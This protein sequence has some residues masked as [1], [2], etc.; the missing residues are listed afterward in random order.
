MA[1][2]KKIE[3]SR[4][5]RY[6]ITVFS[7]R[8]MSGKQ[9]RHFKTWTPPAG[10]SGRALEKELKRAAYEFESQIEYG[11]AP[12]DRR[13][14]AEYAAYCI[15]L[16]ERRG[17]KPSTVA[18][19]KRQVER[20]NEYIGHMRVTDIRPK[21]LN[22]LYK[23]LAQPGAS[24][25]NVF[26]VP[27]ADFRELVGN[28]TYKQ[29]A[30]K[31]G[32]YARLIC[33]LVNGQPISLENAKTIEKNLGRKDLFS[34]VNNDRPMSPGTIR[35]YHELISTVFRQAYNEM[36]ITYN[37]AERATLPKFERAREQRALEPD[38]L[39]AVIEAAQKEPLERYALIMFLLCT[40][41]RRGE[42]VA[43]TWDKVDLK[44]KTVLISASANYTKDLGTYVGTTKTN[45]P[46]EVAIPVEL[47]ELL[48]TYRKEQTREQT[49]LCDAWHGSNLVFPRWN[50]E[51]LNPTMVNYYISDMCKRNG[52]PHINP[53]MFRHSA[54]SILISEG[55]DVL[56][57][58]Q[59]LGHSDITTTLNTYSHALEEAKQ[60]TAECI[61][62]KIL[63]QN[64]A[65]RA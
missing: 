15:E 24:R 39:R 10:L 45:K 51:I 40:G 21:H 25:W 56:T 19:S 33:R 47:A 23:K 2:I 41:C 50:G 34:Y 9:I 38:E 5:T 49:L 43:L 30:E 54:A 26:A 64:N 1:S 16:R 44:K 31:A 42:A 11:F 22:D 17:D 61:S 58:S 8:D 62:E 13:T 29:L 36:I 27:V 28:G 60:K 63:Q 46:R 12:D 55:V 3:S 7:G 53:H 20:V 32:V 18:R 65:F 57:V 52:L 35:S 6:K 48:Y 14:F 37:P 4:G 59:M